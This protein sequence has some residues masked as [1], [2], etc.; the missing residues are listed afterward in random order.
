MTIETQ[1]VNESKHRQSPPA[2]L[3]NDSYLYGPSCQKSGVTTVTTRLVWVGN[4]GPPYVSVILVVQ[5]HPTKNPEVHRTNPRLSSSPPSTVHPHRNPGTRHIHR[6]HYRHH[7]SS[8]G[9][10]KVPVYTRDRHRTRP[11]HPVRG[12]RLHHTHPPTYDPHHHHRPIHPGRCPGT[13]LTRP[14]LPP[15]N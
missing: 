3:R 4:R 2:P 7:N 5:I 13:L 1:K 14:W 8:V 12:L 11:T 9:S 10:P 15:S 6:T